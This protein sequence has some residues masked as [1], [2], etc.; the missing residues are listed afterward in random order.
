MKDHTPLASAVTVVAI[1]LPSTVKFT[2][3]LAR[4]VP[5]SVAL[6][7]VMKSV[8]A[9][10]LEA[11]LAVT[12]GAVAFRRRTT[13]LSVITV[14]E[15]V[16]T[17]RTITVCLRFPRYAQFLRLNFP[18]GHKKLNGQTLALSRRVS[19]WRIGGVLP[20]FAYFVPVFE[21]CHHR[22]RYAGED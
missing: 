16:E 18:I 13:G 14:L 7:E 4:P 22:F 6:F 21:F 15:A 9:P 17:A 2:A 19:G 5:L 10:V 3:V 11:S 8:D 1:G 20:D 12:C